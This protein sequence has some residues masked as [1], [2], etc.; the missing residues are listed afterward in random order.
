MKTVICFFHDVYESVVLWEKKKII[1][2]FVIQTRERPGTSFFLSIIKVLFSRRKEQC[3]SSENNFI[4]CIDLR[5][6]TTLRIGTMRSNPKTVLRWKFRRIRDEL[7]L[8]L[9]ALRQIDVCQLLCSS[10][11]KFTPML[12]TSRLPTIYTAWQ[13]R[14]KTPRILLTAHSWFR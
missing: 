2:G 3:Q 9:F 12:I 11:M 13:Y 14:R 8:S 5:R 7:F 1:K 10:V 4:E 6:L